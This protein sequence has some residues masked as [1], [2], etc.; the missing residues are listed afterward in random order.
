[1][2]RARCLLTAC[3]AMRVEIRRLRAVVVV[4]RE[5]IAKL[6]REL[7]DERMTIAHVHLSRR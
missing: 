7:D 5:I 4:Q 6:Q 3:H 1:M 2:R